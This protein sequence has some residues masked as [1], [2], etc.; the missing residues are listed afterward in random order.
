MF[1]HLIKNCQMFSI[2]VS[3]LTTIVPLAIETDAVRASD[4]NIATT[5]SLYLN[6]RN[7]LVHGNLSLY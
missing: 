7:F 3:R 5:R 6:S 4:K 1:N 2:V